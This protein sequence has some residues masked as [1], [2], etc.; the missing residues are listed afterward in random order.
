MSS[1]LLIGDAHTQ[2]TQLT[3]A[4]TFRLRLTRHRNACSVRPAES[5]PSPRG[6]VRG[7]AGFAW[8]SMPR[9]PSPPC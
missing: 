2:S 9:R 7:D 8:T 5:E 3:H 1:L 4:I 6:I